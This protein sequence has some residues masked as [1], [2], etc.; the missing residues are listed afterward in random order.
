[1]TAWDLGLH[2]LQYL[3]GTQYLGLIYNRISN[4]VEGNQSWSYP[5]FHT[6]W[7][8]AGD[9]STWRSTTDYPFKLNGAA[10]SW[11]SRLQPTVS[12]L[13][14]AAECKATTE[15]G[16]EMVWLRGLLSNISVKQKSP[17]VLCSDSTGAVSL[18]WK[19]IF[20]SRTN[21]IKVQYHWIQ[22]HVEKE[23]IVLRH[24]SNKHMYADLLNKPLCP[25]PF[26]AFRND[27]GLDL[28]PGRLK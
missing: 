24:I 18:T 5:E 6:D 15:V 8:W 27:T 4:T 3:K 14:T 23:T 1:M 13:S 20:H 21:H 2:V 26:K 12:L 17:T 28:I 11:K 7:D 9:L 16:Q 10:I 22:E 19:S 25:G